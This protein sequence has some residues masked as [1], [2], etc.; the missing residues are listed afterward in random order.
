MA[1]LAICITKT[2]I[3]PD[4]CQIDEDENGTSCYF[5]VTGQTSGRDDHLL[6]DAVA[7]GTRIEVFY[8]ERKCSKFKHMGKVHRSQVVGTR[9]SL[10]GLNEVQLFTSIEEPQACEVVDDHQYK[11]KAGALTKVGVPLLEMPSQLMSCFIA[12]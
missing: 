2:S 1:N 3:Y 6:L 8:R 12:F 11:Y 5:L 4:A 9:D 10:F 7:N